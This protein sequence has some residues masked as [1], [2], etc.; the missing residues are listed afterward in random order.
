MAAITPSLS[1]PAEEA[2]SI[3]AVVVILF[4]FLC[5]DFV[6]VEGVELTGDVVEAVAVLSVSEMPEVDLLKLLAVVGGVVVVVVAVVVTVAGGGVVVVVVLL[7]V[8]V[9]AS[10]VT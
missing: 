6:G 8:V 2:T 4:D 1:E 10:S 7:V 3:A 9:V 5:L